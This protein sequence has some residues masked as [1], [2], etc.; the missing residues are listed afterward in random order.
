M[1]IVQDRFFGGRAR[2]GEFATKGAVD[3]Y[4]P[5][6]RLEPVH[7]VIDLHV[8][9]DERSVRGSV[10]HTV[11][12]NAAGAR[13]LV[14]HAVDLDIT[15]VEAGDGAE[16]SH[17]YDGS[18][19]KVTWAAA[20]AKGE[21][22]ELRIAYGSNGP[23]TGI[24]FSGPTDAVPKAPRFAVTDH[25]TERARH[26]LP[27]I[28]LPE[29]RPT[30][31]L[32]LRA[33]AGFTILAN[34]A[35]AGEEPHDDGDKTVTWKQAE[36]C[37]SYLTCFAVGDFVCWDDGEY[38]GKP[39]ACYTTAPF[40]AADLERTFG[41]TKAM[42]AFLEERL[43]S[44][45]PFA[46]YYQFAVEGIGGAMENISLVSWD[47]KFLLD[48]AFESEFG[49][50]IDAIN[51]HEMAHSWFGDHVVC[52]DYAHA[53]LKESWAT[54]IEV[55]WHEHIGGQ[56]ALQYNLWMD[57]RRYFAEADERYHRPIVTRT[58]DTSW[59]MYDMHL[60]PGGA[61]RLHLLRTEL[62]DEVFW[63]A[64]SDY[65]ARFGGSVVETDDFRRLFEE[66]SGRSLGRFFD[67]WLHRP[68]YPKL[69]LTFEHDSEKSEGV[70]RVEQTQVDDKA[71]I[72]LF[73]LPL[74]LSWTIG[75]ETQRGTVEL[76][77]R[78]GRFAF[79]MAASPEMV[80]L[81]PEARLPHT[82]ELE[83]GKQRLEA[84]L[85]GA[86]DVVG[87]ITAGYAL[88]K[89][90]KPAAIAA[91]AG[92]FADEA[93]W[94]VQAE[95]AEALGESGSEAA[96]V[97]LVDIVGS[98][99]VPPAL[100]QVMRAA[101][102]YRD[103]R[104]KDV[105]SAR[106]AQGLPPRAAEAAAEALGRQREAAPLDQLVEVSG[107]TSQGGFA[108]AGALRALGATRR[109]EALETLLE[110]SKVGAID[111]RARAGAAVGLGE[112]ARVLEGRVAERAAEELVTLLR[113]PDRRV[114][115]AAAMALAASGFGA[116]VPALEAF[117]RRLPA[118]ERHAVEQAA[119]RARRDPQASV[120]GLE[121]QVDELRASVR[122]LEDE[123][124]G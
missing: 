51:V 116:A 74:D 111:G 102:R 87:R 118:Q 91:I 69:K 61:L 4:P 12:C 24:L 68:G 15:S 27:T 64:V 30:L 34:G 25:E 71:G 96:L 104:I 101:G 54:Y 120:R 124:R 72:G 23:V 21:E 2:G 94:G 108:Q 57:R 35:R 5:D 119:R 76:R 49:W 114:A 112:L 82:A 29:V 83:V 39:V 40:T 56:D 110:R 9:V 81:D 99:D 59:Q 117:A 95:W 36:P 47:D 113:D 43:G 17:D 93:Y 123:V 41:K 78:V 85:T 28:D 70:F 107:K 31:E 3:H 58:F 18:E 26:W 75:G 62:G 73:D 84:Q 109:A 6:L 122:K 105:L 66:H 14:L 90:G 86:A 8:R 60:Y 121:K 44:D 88:A 65:L 53:W 52:R 45:F 92:A 38:R 16:L 80:R 1:T 10:T 33:E 106:L 115:L 7:L 98:C 48:E 20:F 46:K 67:Q 37:P 50:L 22:R 19:L 103:P 100:A 89:S 32:R 13:R 55:C 11:R 79:P 97:A 42:L 63:P 77:E